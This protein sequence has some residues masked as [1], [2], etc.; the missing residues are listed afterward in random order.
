MKKYKV[1]ISCLIYGQAIIKAENEEE[2]NK[3]LDENL[4]TIGWEETGQGD[5]DIDDIEEIEDE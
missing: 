3:Y 5:I 4:D 1:S 2:L